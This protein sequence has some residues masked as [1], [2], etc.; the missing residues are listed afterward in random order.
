[1]PSQRTARFILFRLRGESFLLDIMGVR[2]ILPFEGATAVPAGPSFLEGLISFRGNPVPVVDLAVRL[3]PGSERPAGAR[4]VVLLVTTDIGEVGLKV[5]EIRKIVAVDLDSIQPTP[6][7]VRGLA[8]RLFF[9]V[10]ESGED[11]FLLIDLESI[12]SPDEKRELMAT[13]PDHDS[14]LTE[15]NVPHP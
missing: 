15:S 3:F 8:G 5:D 4:P 10:V 11:L 12:L 1:M 9:G 14:G 6:S 13:S 2:Q 7:I